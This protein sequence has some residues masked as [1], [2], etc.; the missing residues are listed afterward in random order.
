VIE[1]TTGRD[2]LRLVDEQRPQLVLLD[3]HLPDMSGLEVCRQIKSRSTLPVAV[4][5]ISATYRSEQDRADGLRLSGADAYLTEPVSPDQLVRVLE[6]VLE[7]D[8]TA[9]VPHE[10]GSTKE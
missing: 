4:V 2:T 5:H 9:A 7:H 3:V 8:P 6:R 10:L 1:A